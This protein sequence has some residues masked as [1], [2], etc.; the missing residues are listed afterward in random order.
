MNSEKKRH[1]LIVDDEDHVLSLLTTQLEAM[2]FG[3]HS[4]STANDAFHLL[5]KLHRQ[6]ALPHAIVCDLMMPQVNGLEFCRILRKDLRFFQL[7]FIFL[8]ARDEAESC[9]EG[10][11]NGADDYLTKP[12]KLNE[13]QIR[14]ESLLRRAPA[15]R[16]QYN[17]MIVDRDADALSRTNRMFSHFGFHVTAFS[18]AEDA[19]RALLKDRP[20][21][22]LC[23]PKLN[24]VDGYT[25]CKNIKMNDD[26]RNILF[27]FN[28]G[29]SSLEHQ[30]RAFEAG[31]DASFHDDQSPDE[32]LARLTAMLRRRH[33]RQTGD[34]VVYE[35][36]LRYSLVA[37]GKIARD[38]YTD[39]LKH[40]ET[41]A[42]TGILYL[43][44]REKISKIDYK[45]G[46]IQRITLTDAAGTS[47]R[48]DDGALDEVLQWEEAV[49][50]IYQLLIS[51]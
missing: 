26:L 16:A 15:A 29:E 3:V 47:S 28:I 22:I 34:D 25:L 33:Y 27:V 50:K 31:G 24:G 37:S 18:N 4:A 38:G 49:Y 43:Y 13:L 46:H 21:L 48:E 11:Y 41:H 8:T 40:C 19:F 2:G 6:G 23:T 10:L 9:I 12:Y 42:L 44:R 7:P 45:S 14:I 36:D 5:E 30:K 32:I 51:F 1:I 39:I 20:D 17:V 35:N